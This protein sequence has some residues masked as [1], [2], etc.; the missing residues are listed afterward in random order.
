MKQ[1]KPT[2]TSTFDHAVSAARG[3]AARIAVA[4]SGGLDSSALLHLAHAYAQ[5]HELTLCA[6]HIHHG[7]SPNA[8]AW[9]AHC[10]RE[11]AA[12]NVSFEARRIQLQDAKKSGTEAAARKA[13]YAALGALCRE[14]DVQLLLTAH[15][16]D[17]QAETVLLQLLRGSGPAGLSGMDAANTAASLLQNDNL[18]MARP[19]LQASR[20]Q[21]ES[22]V[23]QHHISHVHDESNDDPRYARNAVRHTVMPA[24]EQHFP[25]FQERFARSAQHAQSATRLLT[26]LAEQDLTATQDG[27]QLDIGKLR[28]LSQDRA[29]NLLRHWF[30]TRGY[31]MPSTAWLSEMLTQLLEAKYDAQ[32]LVT[33]PDC[34]VR[35]Y[36]DRLHLTP[37]LEDLEGTREDQFDDKPGTGFTWN[38]ET[39]MAFPAYGG[40]LHFEPSEQGFDPAWLRAQQLLIEFRRGGEK[41]KPALNRSTR[42]LKYHYQA[43][44]IPAWERGRLPVVKNASHL[45]FAAGIGMDCLHVGAG[46]GRVRLRWQAV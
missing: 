36:R 5:R 10:E 26:E 30:A 45:L 38:G 3:D 21:L 39:E 22:Y 11:C 35:R 1:Q 33:H 44:N 20:K 40:V 24:L 7:L 19:L 41:L 42:L 14:H 13:R 31:S 6:F 17:D 27:D 12:L 46:A 23:S 18:V 15:H 8:D 43:L 16:L 9:L 2:I 4:L 34:H 25:G 37:K 32:L 29:Y 28:T